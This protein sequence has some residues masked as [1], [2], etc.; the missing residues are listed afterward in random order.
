MSP[1]RIADR[2]DIIEKGRV[3]WTGSSADL[4]GADDVKRRY[5]GV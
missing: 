2:R 3:A 1:A 5:L 4:A